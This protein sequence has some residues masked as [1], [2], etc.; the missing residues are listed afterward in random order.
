MAEVVGQGKQSTLIFIKEKPVLFDAQAISK[1]CDWFDLAMMFNLL[2]DETVTVLSTRK[3]KDSPI[4]K[5]QGCVSFEYKGRKVELMNF[6]DGYRTSG[7]RELSYEELKS[8][9]FEDRTTY[10]MAKRR[11]NTV[12]KMDK[13][14]FC[15][16]SGRNCGCWTAGGSLN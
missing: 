12:T 4:G 16:H 6:E 2:L 11:Y 15:C 1:A 14:Y 7:F 3:V 9:Y 13:T 5:L 8:N 10:L